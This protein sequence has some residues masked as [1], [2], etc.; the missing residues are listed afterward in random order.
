METAVG[1]PLTGIGDQELESWCLGSDPSFADFKIK[2]WLQERE[3][4]GPGECQV[5]GREC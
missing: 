5:S 1:T 2:C 4:E 3:H